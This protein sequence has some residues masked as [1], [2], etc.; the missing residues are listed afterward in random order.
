MKLDGEETAAVEE[1]SVSDAKAEDVKKPEKRDNCP[2]RDDREEDP[3][4][5][6]LTF[7]DV[8]GDDDD[9]DESHKKGKALKIIA[10]ILCILVAAEFCGSQKDQSG[11]WRGYGAF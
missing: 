2:P 1:V 3:E 6:K 5:H 4:E 9:S 10:V 7:D 11:V 8:F